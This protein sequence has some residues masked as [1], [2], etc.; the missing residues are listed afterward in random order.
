M[1]HGA[2]TGKADDSI[3]KR[4]LPQAFF[5][6]EWGGASRTHAGRMRKASETHQEWYPEPGLNRHSQRPRDFK[7]LVSTNSTIRAWDRQQEG[8]VSGAAAASSACACVAGDSPS[9]SSSS[10][11]GTGQSGV[12]AT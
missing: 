1:R 11:S 9:P 7:S 8:V 4:L 10:G 2:G 5:R 12:D 3:H 6:R